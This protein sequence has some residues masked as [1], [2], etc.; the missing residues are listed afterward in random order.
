MKRKLTDVQVHEIANKR[1]NGTPIRKLC[2]EY[3][4]SRSTIAKAFRRLGI[5]IKDKVGNNIKKQ[6]VNAYIKEGKSTVS[7][8]RTFGVD[9]HTVARYIRNAGNTIRDKEGWRVL[10][11]RPAVNCLMGS[12]RN[13]AAKRNIPFSLSSKLFEELTQKNCYYCNTPSANCISVSGDT[14]TY[15][16]LDRIDSSDGYIETNV[17]PCCF[18]CNSAKNNKTL[19]QFK[20]WLTSLIVNDP[21]S[22]VNLL[23]NKTLP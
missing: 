4:I 20:V 22:K 19:H 13:A 1:R 14:Y 18:S 2:E 16:G 23:L 12:Y 15:T 7:I 21:L 9:H 5:S 17:V 10:N 8:A 11:G 6:M 3:A